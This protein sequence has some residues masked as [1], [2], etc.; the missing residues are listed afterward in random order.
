M[1]TSGES[2]GTD[3]LKIAHQN[4]LQQLTYQLGQRIAADRA[5]KQLETT[6]R[7]S[8]EDLRGVACP[9]RILVLLNELLDE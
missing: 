4:C 8:T 1:F 7:P 3:S 6:P 5:P 9:E 2:D